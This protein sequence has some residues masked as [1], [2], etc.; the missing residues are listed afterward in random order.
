MPCARTRAWSCSRHGRPHASPHGTSPTTPAR[1]ASTCAALSCTSGR[2]GAPRGVPPRLRRHA[3]PSRHLQTA[4]SSPSCARALGR[5]PC[6]RASGAPRT[7]GASCHTAARGLAHAFARA[8]NVCACASSPAR[9]RQ[10]HSRPR[11]QSPHGPPGRR[12]AAPSLRL[13][14]C[15]EDGAEGPPCSVAMRAG[16]TDW[17]VGSW[18]LWPFGPR[19]PHTVAAQTPRRPDPA[20]EQSTAAQCARPTRSRTRAWHGADSGFPRHKQV[21]TPGTT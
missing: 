2:G 1:C 12:Q 20:P 4:R 14:A 6:R 5:R 15:H 3:V 21:L 11:P 18:E 8:S 19:H 10:A 17:W 7:P 13:T 16:G 9:P